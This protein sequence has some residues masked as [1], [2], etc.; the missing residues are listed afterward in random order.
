RTAA[1]VLYLESFGNPRKFSRLARGLARTK[2][3]IAVR[4]AESDVAQRAAASHTAAAATPA[5]TRDAL[6]EQ[7]GVIAVDT[8]SEVTDVLAAPGWQPLPAGNRVAILSNAG[9]AGV[10]AAGAC[11][12]NGLI[13]SPLAV[14][15]KEKLAALLPAQA[16]LDNPVDTTA[17]IDAAT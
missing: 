4:S 1:A 10:L 13:V 2:P 17:G 8:V 12:H 11:V 16:T 6:F 15:T 7:A 9:G 3:V 5:V 14:V